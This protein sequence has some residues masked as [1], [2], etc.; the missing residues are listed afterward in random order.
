MTTASGS[1][2]DGAS[3]FGTTYPKVYLDGIQL[4][5]PLVLTRIQPSMIDRIEVIRGPQGAALYGADAISGVTNIVSRHD[6]GAQSPRGRV[7]A[8]FGLAR[9]DYSANPA[10]EQGYAGAVR[11]GSNVRSAALDVDAGSTGEYFPSTYSRRL[12]ATAVGRQVGARSILTGTL[13][14]FGMRSGTGESPII[15]RL[16]ESFR[17]DSTTGPLATPGTGIETLAQYTFGGTARFFPNDRWQH[18]FVGGVDGYVLSGVPDERSPIPFAKV[19]ALNDARGAAA[20]ATLRAS[21]VLNLGSAENGNRAN[22]TFSVEQSVLRERAVIEQAVPSAPGTSVDSLRTLEVVRW[23]GNTGF[24]TQLNAALFGNQLFLTGGARVERD[25]GS[26]GT[27]RWASLPMVGVAWAR[28]HESVTL[29]LRGAYGKG[30]RWPEIPARETLWEGLRPH[31]PSKTL[32]PEEQ[33]GVEV[34]VDLHVGRTFTVQVTRF[35]QLASGLIQRVALARDT[36]VVPVAVHQRIAFALQ[37][38]GEVTNRGWE[39]QAALRRGTLALSSAFTQVSSRV[40]K[41]AP[42]YTGDL[43][44]GDRMLEVPARTVSVTGSWASPRVSAS[45]TAYRAMD[46]IT[47]DRI[48]LAHAFVTSGRPTRNF[49]GPKLRNFWKEYPGLTHLEATLGWTLNRGL[50]FTLTGRNLLDC[51][52]GEPDNITVLPGRSVSL[53]IRTEF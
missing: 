32:L 35:D 5:N 52:T 25:E 23:R 14:F 48:A 10:F 49:V 19:S 40:R 16:M 8:G 34:G 36:G 17:N 13:R 27:G 18:T 50:G 1:C 39:M 51:Q 33:S 7:N 26:A 2:V 38:V 3:S 22:L 46:W 20:R 6:A 15:T 47:Y 11:L 12:V 42:G 4:A 24:T 37:N 29:K 41:V 45:I 44:P 9:S 21:S 31:S 43:A 53:G 28:D 30:I